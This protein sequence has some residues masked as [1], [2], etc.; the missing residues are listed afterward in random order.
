M[1]DSFILCHLCNEDRTMNDI[2]WEPTH[3][4]FYQDHKDTVDQIDVM[5]VSDGSGNGPGYTHE[6]WDATASADF[7]RDH[8]GNWTFQG[9]TF[10]GYVEPL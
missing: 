8:Y 5:F 1:T 4:I 6:E 2:P 7:E 9:D 3:R 10:E